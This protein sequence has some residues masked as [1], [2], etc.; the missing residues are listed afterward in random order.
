MEQKPIV[1]LYKH[2]NSI[3]DKKKQ[4]AIFALVCEGN[5]FCSSPGFVLAQALLANMVGMYCLYHG[6]QGLRNIATKVHTLTRDV[7]ESQRGNSFRNAH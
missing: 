5:F 2:V 3:F 6:R 4:R 1:S 7:A